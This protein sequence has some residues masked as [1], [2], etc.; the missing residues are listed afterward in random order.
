MPVKQIC[1]DGG[2]V[3]ANSDLAFAFKSQRA[4][5][6]FVSANCTFRSLTSLYLLFSPLPELSVG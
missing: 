4:I 6:V 3:L 1:F 5:S 2:E